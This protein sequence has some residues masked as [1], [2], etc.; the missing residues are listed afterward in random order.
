MIFSIG[1][2]KTF[3]KN[4]TWVHDVISQKTSLPVYYSQPL[5]FKSTLFA[6]LWYCH[7]FSLPSGT[8]LSSV[9]R[10]CRKDTGEKESSFPGF[11]VPFSFYFCLQKDTQFQQHSSS[12]LPRDK[13]SG[14]HGWGREGSEGYTQNIFE[15]CLG[16]KYLI[17]WVSEDTRLNKSA[18][19]SVS[20][21]FVSD[22]MYSN[23]KS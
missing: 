17:S 12:Q 3:D 9:S 1:A 22:V 7:I 11:S 14:T 20:Y 16:I 18:L 19:Y 15:Y 10:R 8:M 21:S 2:E 5:G 6:Y 13:F 4:S 23:F